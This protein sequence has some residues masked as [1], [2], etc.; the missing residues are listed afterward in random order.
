MSYL[1]FLIIF[2]CLPLLVSLCAKKLLTKPNKTERLPIALMAL[3]ALVY[4]TPWDNYL[5]MRG[6]WTYPT[7]GVVGVLGYVPIEEY[8][9]M[10]LHHLKNFEASSNQSIHHIQKEDS[11]FSFVPKS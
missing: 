4:T 7:G 8:F 5:I 2:V 6:V 11:L 1:K 3:V 9:F 10:V